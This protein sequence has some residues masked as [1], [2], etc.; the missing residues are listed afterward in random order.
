[1]K[2]TIFKRGTAGLL[3]L[4]LCIT[5]LLGI[6]ATTAYAA[7]GETSEAVMISFPRDGDANY[8]ADWG[9]GAKKYM[10]GWSAGEGN[11]NTVYA[12]GS[13]YGNACYCIEPGTPL[14]IG[15][16]FVSK[17]ESYWDNYPST[18]NHTITPYEI[19]HFIG[20]IF[21]YGYTGTIDTAWRSQNA[22]DADKLSH[23]IAT[24][25]VIWETVVGERDSDF[26][27]VN[28]GS[29]DT[30]LSI[31]GANHPLRTQIMS[32]YNSI[33]SSVQ[34]HSKVPSFCSKT[35]GK[36]QNIE[37]D[38]D[39]SK[40]TTT[41][42]DT[43]NVLANYKFTASQSGITF[44]TNGNKLTITTT[45]APSSAVTIT[46]EKVGSVRS[47]VIVWDDGTYAPGVGRQNLTTYAQTVNDPVQGYVNIKVSTGSA[48]IVKTSEDG[49]VDGIT[50]TLAGNGV[51]QTVKTNSK[52]EVQ[53][54]NLMPGVYTV[55]EQTY[56]RYEPQE[57]HRVTVVSGQVAKVN[58]NNVL[59]RGDIQVIK[60]SE[61]DF[62]EGVK[63]HLFGTSLSGIAVDEYAVTDKNGIATFEDVLISGSN[64]YTIE[65]IDT[66]IR[67]VVPDNQTAPV[68]WNDVTSRTFVNVL[69]KFTVT[70]TKSDAEKGY[71]QGDASLG[72]AI[73]GIY[74]GGTLVDQ[75]TTDKNGQ[76]TSKEYVCGDDW[77]VKEITPSEGYLLDTNSYKIGAEAKLYT[78]EHNQTSNDVTE[79]VIKGNIAIIKHTD[80]GSTQI[81]TP[82]SG[83]AFE[84]YLKSSRSFGAADADERDTIICDENGFGQ[85]KD[86]PYGIYTVHQTEDWDGRELMD[87][88]D[89]FISADGN[90]YR[91][92][93]NNRNFES[94][95]KVVKIDAE[96]EKVIPYAGAGF[97]IYAPD[98][99]Q[100]TM[101]FTYPTPTTIETFFTDANGCLVT[102]EK[103]EYGKGY[104][105]VECEAPYGYVLDET[106]VY[107]DVVEDKS[108]DE[109]GVTLI[110]VSKPNMAQKGTITVSKDGEVFFGVS[111]SGGVDESGS[112]LPIIYQPEYEVAGLKDATYE[113][114]AAEN[115]VTPDGTQRYAAGELV[116]T[117]TTD[118]SGMAKSKE[119][120]LGKYEIKE[121]EAPYGMLL[122]DETHTVELTYAG[123]NVSVT[124]T[125]TS[126]Y[127]ER[128]KASVSLSKSIETNDIF[129]IG[130]NGEIKNISFGL[131]AAEELVSTSGT[132]I[133]ADGLIEIIT[134][135]ENGNATVNTDLP[136]GKYYIKELAT[137]EHYILNDAKYPI[138]FSYAGQSVATVEL[139]ANEGKAIK[140]D[141][142]Y[143]SVAGRKID[144]NGDALGD[145]LIGLFKT[146]DGEFTR[147][148]ALMTTTSAEDGSFSFDRIPYG[149][150][151]V[152][153]IEQPTGFVL[154]E[155]VF[156]VEIE[157]NGQTVAVEIV[158]EYIR[159]NITL[160]KVDAEYPDNKLT[161]ATFVVYK[162]SNDNG[163]LDESDELLG[164][165][166]EVNTGIYEMNELY[167]GRYFVKETKAPEG[168]LLDEGVYEVFIDTDEQTYSVENKAGVGFIN[169]AMCGSLK[170]VKTSSDGKVKGFTFRITGANGYD[171][172]LD[173]DENGEILI[174]NLR[175]GEYTV[176]E[177][178]NAASSVYVIPADKVASVKYD[179]TT[180]VEM[181]NVLRDTPKTGDNSN[182]GLWAAVAGLSAVGIAVCGILGFK[183]KKED[184]A[185]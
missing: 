83:A 98:G 57:S 72:G 94:Y 67:Y 54:D 163:K 19:K 77:T 114:R 93:I 41:L 20:R 177:V 75:Y 105:I 50:F 139:A 156:T 34:K 35:T 6:G 170:I 24:Q 46:A 167:Y 113:I 127:N 171:V 80:D 159:G 82:E 74:K 9:H 17:D 65:E 158:N 119:L 145:A 99:S 14:A 166:T 152:R 123:Q 137:D 121:V 63:F 66:A 47:G 4:V 53:L 176:S 11:H 108:T 7:A 48:K 62:N 125:A 184:E 60:S 76:F 64:P 149:T 86:M 42:T 95:V 124:E 179:A 2:K 92:L 61:D 157:K 118:E 81:E 175:I 178:N 101:S 151:Y 37:F 97:K 55:T 68:V 22:A 135:D 129:G 116:D 133:P 162:D 168:F 90:T 148:N 142:I 117:I 100:I 38:W 32:H 45:T 150:W 78:V 71:A 144:E 1:M 91:Y 141:L 18:Y 89:V 15:D 88:F 69:K 174:N 169:K 140:N 30:V 164:T 185:E 29:Y 21:Q 70:V 109:G 154:D 180:I 132:S 43:N 52:G 112:E 27:H 12:I 79:D 49:K 183:K 84:I 31:I 5:G 110:K 172:T 87:D 39:G 28:T 51:N 120:Y 146:S 182:I 122:S 40:Y 111:V 126:F 130:M 33:V 107:F 3:A 8:S 173:T 103:L 13:W 26:N 104:S 181:H 155:T 147:E 56:D 136:F 96:T 102:P 161:G 44:T 128:E 85:T 58:F 143:G 73:Y 59:K 36:A 16:T 160:T 25:I 165:L 10:N 115:V 134:L 138:S 131:F 106:P 23:C 153:E